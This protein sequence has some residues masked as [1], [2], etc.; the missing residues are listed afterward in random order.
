MDGGNGLMARELRS[1][2]RRIGGLWADG[3][4]LGTPP[5]LYDKLS[6]FTF[7][8]FCL[9]VLVLLYCYVAASYGY[10]ELGEF[11]E[12]ENNP[13]EPLTAA[14]FAGSGLT[15]FL[16][17]AAAGRGWLRRFYILA[18]LGALFVAGEEVS[19]GQHIFGFVPPDFLVSANF[20]RESNLHNTYALA[21]IFGFLYIAILPLCYLV[22]IAAFSARKYRLGPLPLP[23]LWLA[24]FFALAANFNGRYSWLGIITFQGHL[25]LILGIFLGAALFA[26]DKRLLMVVGSITALSCSALL[27]HGKFAPYY[28]PGYLVAEIS[29]YLL[30][31]AGFLYCLQ[32]LRD[33][34]G[35][36]WREWGRR[37][38]AAGFR[39]RG[40]AVDVITPPPPTYMRISVRR[41]R[42]G[43]AIP[44]GGLGRR[45]ACW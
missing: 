35:G 12:R 20:L 26:R 7:S 17:A 41:V 23:S 11:S 8:V 3:N 34:G 14:L 44:G 24:F 32:L 33:S 25:L 28:W 43:R 40:R 10:L 16:A 45:L 15:L 27:T 13:V 38:K 22:T 31:L 36:R 30:S 29:E 18:G 21:P 42:V 2:G 19:W 1:W 6:L 5:G 39:I 9:N 4:G 37:V